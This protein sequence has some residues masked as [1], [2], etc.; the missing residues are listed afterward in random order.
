M[1]SCTMDEYHYYHY[2]HCHSF[3]HSWW[4]DT[5]LYKKFVKHFYTKFV[6]TFVNLFASK[7]N[8]DSAEWEKP[9]IPETIKKHLN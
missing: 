3:I 6:K 4:I 1:E 8:W 9:Q 5:N 7:P 2:Y